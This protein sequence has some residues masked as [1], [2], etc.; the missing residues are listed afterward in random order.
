MRTQTIIVKVVYWDHQNLAERIETFWASML[1]CVEIRGTSQG[2]LNIPVTAWSVQPEKKKTLGQHVNDWYQSQDQVKTILQILRLHVNFIHDTFV[3][4]TVIDWETD[5]KTESSRT[6]E[7]SCC[8]GGGGGGGRD[9][10]LNKERKA[11][12]KW[13]RRFAH[14]LHQ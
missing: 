13:G 11:E 12:D 5:T 1:A 2:M 7:A 14:G 8:H 6:T 10:F 4:D 3:K 9:K